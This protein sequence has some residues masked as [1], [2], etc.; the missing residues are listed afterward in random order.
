M[1]TT[2]FDPSTNILQIYTL[3]ELKVNP[4]SDSM[5]NTSHAKTPSFVHR[6]LE[7]SDRLYVKQ[8]T[9]WIPTFTMSFTIRNTRS[10]PLVFPKNTLL[11]MIKV[12]PMSFLGLTS[13]NIDNIEPIFR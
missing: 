2:I 1:T 12:K 13:H 6:I 4:D 9:H 11:A 3:E 10:V 7:Y 5:V 8:T